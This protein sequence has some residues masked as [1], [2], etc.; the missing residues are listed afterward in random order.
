MGAGPLHL[1]RRFAGSLVPVGPSPTDR[2]WAESLLGDGERGL[3]HRMRAADRRHAAGVARRV[4]AAMPDAGREVLAAALLH[5]VGKVES[6]LGTY[7]RV[8]ATVCGRVADERTVDDWVRSRGITR[9]IGLYLRHPRL[10]AEMLRMAGAD[11]LTA[12]WAAEHHLPPEEWTVPP[13]VGQVLKDAD[14]D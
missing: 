11:E 2:Q 5:D 8:V 1:V 9:R 14:D 12:A 10:G 6:R 7:L 13:A 3:W 4:Q